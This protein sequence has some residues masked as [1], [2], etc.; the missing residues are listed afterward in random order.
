[1][2]LNNHIADDSMLSIRLELVSDHN[3]KYWPI[4]PDEVPA[5]FD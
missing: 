2:V 1:V 4:G 3:S 5:W